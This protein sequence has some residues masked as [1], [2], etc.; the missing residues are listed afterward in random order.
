MTSET[1]EMHVDLPTVKWEGDDARGRVFVRLREGRLSLTGEIR[2]RKAGWK[3]VNAGQ[4]LKSLVEMY[5]CNPLMQSIAAVWE[6]WHLND[7]RAGCEHQRAEKWEDIPVDPDQPKDAYLIT[8]GY[9][10]WNMM[11]WKPYDQGGFLN[12]P[13]PTCGYGYGSKWLFE[14]LPQDVLDTIQEWRNDER[15]TVKETA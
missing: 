15:F 7:M 14:K 13:C 5:P 4:C 9:T 8:K 6:R 11:I 3:V 2:E 10:G 1:F 12:K